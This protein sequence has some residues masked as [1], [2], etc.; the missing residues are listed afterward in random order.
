MC[1]HWKFNRWVFLFYALAWFNIHEGFQ[2]IQ[3]RAE[4]YLAELQDVGFS[5][6][7]L[8][9]LNL[10]LKSK[11]LLPK[12]TDLYFSINKIGFFS[13]FMCQPVYHGIK[14]SVH[15]IAVNCFLWLADG[16][17]GILYQK[18]VWFY[19]VWVGRI[20]VSYWGEKVESLIKHYIMCDKQTCVLYA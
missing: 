8:V 14:Y 7:L 9:K 13:N 1:K 19:F 11:Y 12:G 17:I 16:Y 4:K 2:C 18:S 15:E 3:F 20:I 10:I 6:L 5:L